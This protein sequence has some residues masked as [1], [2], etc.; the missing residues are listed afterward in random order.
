MCDLSLEAAKKLQDSY[1]SQPLALVDE[2]N[3]Q[4]NF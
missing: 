4:G 1:F 2:K 3:G